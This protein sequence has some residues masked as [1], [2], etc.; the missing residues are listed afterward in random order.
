M[1]AAKEG[2]RLSPNATHLAID[3][4]T[5]QIDLANYDDAEKHAELA[6]T[7]DPAQAH[8]LL[9]RIWIGRKKMDRAEVEAKKAMESAR[10]RVA[11]LITMALVRREQGQHEAALKLLEQAVEKKQKRE[12]IA[13]LY[14]LRGDM[15]A[16]LGLAEEA[17][18]DFRREIEL[19]PESPQAY[20]NLALLLVA[21]GRIEEATALIRKL[22]AEAPFPG[23]Y[24]T[25]CQ[26]LETVGDQRG[27]RYWARR[28]LAQF[29]EDRTLR[30]LAS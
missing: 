8:D 12:E 17:E 10:D 26:I 7:T 5:L 18:R 29:P 16:R 23:S 21:A 25:V 20:R 19:F 15:R 13:S 11:P 6:L 28:G 3:V 4:A 27:V 24:H 1:T 2:L 22:V 9:A 30:R 14:F